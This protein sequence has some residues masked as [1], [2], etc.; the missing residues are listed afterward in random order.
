[1]VRRSLLATL[2][3]AE[4]ISSATSAQKFLAKNS[5]NK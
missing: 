5:K 2:Q 1:M 4:N 3:T